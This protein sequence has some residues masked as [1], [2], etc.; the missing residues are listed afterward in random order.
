MADDLASLGR[1]SA[2]ALLILVSLAGG[3][4]HGYAIMDDIAALAGARP[5]PGTLYGALA[6]LE[7]RGLIAPVTAADD[8]R[9]PYC[10]TT[11]GAAALRTHL[12]G[13]EQLVRTGLHRLTRLVP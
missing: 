4:K 2:P 11:A 12:E 10:L 1:F 6:R 8:R 5:G 3:P 13:M 7:A 9:R